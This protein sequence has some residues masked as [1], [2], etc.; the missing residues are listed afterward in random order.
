M[1]KPI[2]SNTEVISSNNPSVCCIYMHK[3]TFK[4]IS[5]SHFYL[6][7]PS[8]SFILSMFKLL[9]SVTLLDRRFSLSPQCCWLF[10]R[11]A[12]DMRRL[13]SCCPASGDNIYHLQQQALL[14][15][16]LSILRPHT[17][18]KP[19]NVEN[20]KSRPHSGGDQ[21]SNDVNRL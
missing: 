8:F 4:H 5:S 9:R 15:H 11:A 2:C 10:I 17:S 18:S 6:L 20:R 14:H 1:I 19:V 21:A 12:W 3:I 7:P 16:T 13:L